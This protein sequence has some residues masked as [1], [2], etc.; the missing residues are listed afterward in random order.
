MANTFEFYEK[1]NAKS[2]EEIV[3]FL[4]ARFKK[5]GKIT[6]NRV[7]NGAIFKGCRTVMSPYSYKGNVIV[8][9]KDEMLSVEMS[10]KLGVKILGILCGL[11]A[12]ALALAAL[13]DFRLFLPCGIA[14]IMLAFSCIGEQKKSA[15]VLEQI[16]N[17]L[18]KRF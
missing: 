18:K 2:V 11:F 5:Y 9:K 1:V 6:M 17:D 15:K 3:D 7:E 4:E 12:I 13:E 14:A 10:G 8:N 16:M